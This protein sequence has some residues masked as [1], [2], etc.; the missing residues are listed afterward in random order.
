MTAP[1]VVDLFSGAGGWSTGLAMH[2]I[3]DVGLE[4][5]HPAAATARA[6][7]HRVVRADVA[8]YPPDPFAGWAGLIASPPCQTFS[9]AGH[10]GGR[11][12][13]GALRSHVLNCRHEWTPPHGLAADSRTELV[14]EPLRWAHAVHPRWIALEQVPAVLPLWHAYGLALADMGYAT[15]TGMVDAADYGVPQHRHRALLLASRDGQPHR[16]ARTHG[17]TGQPLHVTMAEAV[18][19]GAGQ[20]VNTGRDW[21]TDGTGR[22]GAQRIPMDRPAPALTGKSGGQWHI[23]PVAPG[24]PPAV[25]RRLTI[26]DAGA[27]QSFPPGYPFTGTLS[28]RFLQ[29]GNA[30][31]P[32]L[33]AA[34]VLEVTTC[35]AVVRSARA[36]AARISGE[37]KQCGL[38]G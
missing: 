2:G 37:A 27:L 14:L 31:P 13:L 4:H 1:S 12:A 9:S 16:P 11:S 30:V 29:A 8:A 20:E 21:P 26:A 38:F 3:T 36:V 33:A 15:W 28:D 34:A 32:L 25:V 17:G 22:A 6:S 23:A 10:K 19:W 24:L 35:R 18:G 5:W 7:G